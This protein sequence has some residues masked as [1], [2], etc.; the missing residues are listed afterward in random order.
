MHEHVAAVSERDDERVKNSAPLGLGIPNESES[1][2]VDLGELTRLAWSHT[3]REPAPIGKAAVL[4]CKPM[5]RAVRDL[6]S[7]TFE[8]TVNLAQAKTSLLPIA[9]QPR[10]DFLSLAKELLLYRTEI[11]LLWNRA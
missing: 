4:H 5:K 10:A 11:D 6:H 9:F 1:S 2:E 3:D 7:L 8:K